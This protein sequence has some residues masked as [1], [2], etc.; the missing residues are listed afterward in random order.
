MR[1]HLN[2]GL[3][4]DRFEVDWWVNSHRVEQRL[5]SHP[6]P[7]I[8][9]ADYQKAGAI[10]VP[11]LSPLKNHAIINNPLVL[12]EI[13][14]DIQAIKSKDPAQALEW[15]LYTR[16]VFGELFTNGYLIVDFVH[17]DLDDQPRSYY[18]LCY[19]EATL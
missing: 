17:E 19:G 18:V 10:I 13:P 2:Q 11:S 14:A 12:I 15:R 9:L 3:P 7:Q 5:S 16:K 1:D 8:D 6:R 4:S